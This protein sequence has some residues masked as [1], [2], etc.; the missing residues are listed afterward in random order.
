MDPVIALL[1]GLVIGAALGAA[2]LALIRR[3]GPAGSADAALVA[4]ER[5]W[6]DER[7]HWTRREGELAAELAAAT[8]TAEGLQRQLGG[9]QQQVRELMERQRSE[10]AS[11]Q[12]RERGE[13]RVLEALAPV[14]QS[15]ADMQ[16][17]VTDLEHQRRMQHGELSQQLRSATES[18]ERLRATADSLASALRNNSTRGVWGETQ[19][20]SVVEAAGLLQR[21]DFDVQSS[22]TSESGTGR[23]DMIVRL[24]G[25][26]SIAVDAKVPF[27]AY[28]DASAIPATAGDAELARRDALLRQHVKA[29]RDHVSALGDR[30]YWTACRRAPRW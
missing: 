6:T 13:S 17:K 19:L 21:V 15:L 5:R 2:A 16:S 14:A 29:V 27:N 25:G 18:E 30:R 26:K 1:L 10:Q 28:L 24:P 12:Q 7:M 8:A 23:P 4:A 20:R 9:S 3:G 22:I 11:A